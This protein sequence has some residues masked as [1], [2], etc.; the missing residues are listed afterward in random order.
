[1]ALLAGARGAHV[2]GIDPARR[3]IEVA[4]AQAAERGLGVRFVLGDAGQLPVPDGQADVVL[5][6]FGLIFAPDPSVAAAEIARVSAPTAR[7][8]LSAWIPEGA[9]AEIARVGAD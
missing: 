2:V 3:L 8:A 6:S 5:S 1:A 9:L 7:I 4:R